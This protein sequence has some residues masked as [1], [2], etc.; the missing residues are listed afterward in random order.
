LF[1]R[2]L[3]IFLSVWICA[4][5]FWFLHLSRALASQSFKQHFNTFVKHYDLFLKRSKV[6]ED[7]NFRTVPVL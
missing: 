4:I 5:C 1:L 2:V 3:Q 6:F 7:V